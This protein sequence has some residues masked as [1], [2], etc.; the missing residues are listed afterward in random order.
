[1]DLQIVHPL[2]G[3]DSVPCYQADDQHRWVPQYGT[4]DASAA[5][6]SSD[7]KQEVRNEKSADQQ[8]HE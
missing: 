4:D 5:H 3:E 6:E 7:V 2:D 1:M 8:K